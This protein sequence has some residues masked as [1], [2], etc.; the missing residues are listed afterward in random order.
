MA[1][2]ANVH[3]T[4]AE[5]PTTPLPAAPA[6]GSV[7]AQNVG[8]LQY[9]EASLDEDEEFHF[10]RFEHLQR[11]NLVAL[12]MKL[13]RTKDALSKASTISD[14][15]LEKLR[16]NLEQYGKHTRIASYS[17][18]LTDVS[19]CNTKLPLP[20]GKKESNLK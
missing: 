11:T 17:T 6:L 9:V 5:P 2:T 16:T 10:L 12:Q 14:E 3:T 13:I 4:A 1:T 18:F 8:L 19:Y 20:A 15:D 7:E